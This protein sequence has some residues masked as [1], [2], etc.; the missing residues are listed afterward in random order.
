MKVSHLF[1]ALT[2]KEI[3]HCHSHPYNNNRKLDTVEKKGDFSSTH[4]RTEVT[5]KL[6]FPNLMRQMNSKSHS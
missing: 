5:G 1:L 3:G 2:C 6:P 4:Q